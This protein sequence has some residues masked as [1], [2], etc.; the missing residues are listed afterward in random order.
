MGI[1]LISLSSAT[2]H[3]AS[4]DATTSG[5]ARIFMVPGSISQRHRVSRVLA[6]L[7]ATLYVVIVLCRPCLALISH[8]QIRK[9]ENKKKC[10]FS[11]LDASILCAT[12]GCCCFHKVNHVYNLEIYRFRSFK[13]VK[14]L[15]SYKTNRAL[16]GIEACR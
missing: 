15:L 3:L 7:L 12:G 9:R 11:L 2:Y 4:F 13:N 16:R 10:N 1:E 14:F 6:T 8:T 5:V